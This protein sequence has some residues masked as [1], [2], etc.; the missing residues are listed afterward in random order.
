KRG[1]SRIGRRVGPRYHFPQAAVTLRHGLAPTRVGVVSH[2]VGNTCAETR[3]WLIS[4]RGAAPTLKSL[5]AAGAGVLSP[6]T[7]LRIAKWTCQKRMRAVKH[8]WALVVPFLIAVALPSKA[9]AADVQRNIPYAK[10]AHERQVLDVYAPHGGK[11]LPVVFWIHGG[12][13]ETG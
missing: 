10:P 1:T 5:D 7:G 2:H 12:G 3:H 8:F 6:L 4:D 11:N 9:R 13:W